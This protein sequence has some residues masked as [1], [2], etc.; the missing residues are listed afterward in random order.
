[1]HYEIVERV[2][3]KVAMR[4][5]KKRHDVETNIRQT[6]APNKDNDICATLGCSL[7]QQVDSVREYVIN[8]HIVHL[9]HDKEI[10]MDVVWSC[11]I[12]ANEDM[13][14]DKPLLIIL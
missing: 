14:T 2:R 4:G 1:M 11:R 7:T 13:L 12:V 8:R 5:K 6:M 9:W 3:N 10:N